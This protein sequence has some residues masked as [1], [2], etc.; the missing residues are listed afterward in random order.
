MPME[1]WTSIQNAHRR[2]LAGYPAQP[3]YDV[4]RISNAVLA[5]T[6]QFASILSGDRRNMEPVCRCYTEFADL[7]PIVSQG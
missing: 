6:A 1:V 7:V 3:T 2:T 5:M 4:V